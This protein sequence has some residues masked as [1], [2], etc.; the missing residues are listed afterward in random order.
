MQ[1]SV[2]IIQYYCPVYAM[3][4]CN[5]KILILNMFFFFYSYGRLQFNGSLKATESGTTHRSDILPWALLSR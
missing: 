2:T 3:F 5:N 1:C 4:Y